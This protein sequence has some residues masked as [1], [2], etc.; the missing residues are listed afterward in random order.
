MLYCSNNLQTDYC[1]CMSGKYAFMTTTVFL[2]NTIHMS[3]KVQ[4]VKKNAQINLY[5]VMAVIRDSA[6]R[7]SCISVQLTA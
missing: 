2:R 5:F 1:T 7:I 4:V 3:T 6:S